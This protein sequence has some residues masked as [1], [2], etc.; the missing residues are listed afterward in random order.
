[1]LDVLLRPFLRHLVGRPPSRRGASATRPRG[2]TYRSVAYLPLRPGQ[3]RTRTF[4]MRRR[5][6]DPVEVAA[7]LDRVADD[8][9]ALYGRWA[10]ALS[11]RGEG[12]A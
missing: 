7:F 3:V 5:G 9:E 10:A 1:M 4:T 8:L 2:G 11:A 6:A 12:V